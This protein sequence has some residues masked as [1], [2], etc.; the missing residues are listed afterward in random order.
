MINMRGVHEGTTCS[1][2]IPLPIVRLEEPAMSKPSERNAASDVDLSRYAFTLYELAAA[3]VALTLLGL[4]LIPASAGVRNTSKHSRCLANL[5]RIGYGNTIYAAHDPDAMALPIP[6]R[7]FCQCPGGDPCMEPIYIGP[8][9]WG[10]KSGVGKAGDGVAYGRGAPVEGPLA[11]MSSRFGTA[12]EFGPARRP[13]NAIL[14]KQEFEDHTDQQEY[15]EADTLLEL[16]TYRC[17]SDNGYT[18]VHHPEFR[19]ER[20][21]AYDHYGTSYGANVFMI[22]S[23]GGGWMRSN[24]PYMRRMSEI[25]NPARTLAFQE[26]NGRFAWT[27]A[28]EQP[29]C[30]FIGP[31][32]PGTVRGWHGK[33]WTFNAAF[34]DGHVDTI[35]MR[36]YDNPRVMRD[37]ALNE[38]YRCI[39]IRGENWQKDTLPA[40]LV[41]T[42][43]W[44]DG[45]GRPSYEGG[46][47]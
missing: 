13:L 6:G 24:S 3:V 20:R 39:I 40:E 19:D 2:D 14:Y 18:G 27:A 45:S 41:P 9:E 32:I 1:P 42:P 21:T 34:V 29:E 38:M 8:Y 43:V 10:G 4:C 44:H 26:D 17:P 15:W 35:F 7:H 16:D 22:A 33:D 30:D 37:G 46:I 31:G 12:A 5:M 47:E 23:S 36:G 25:L 28:P 11:W